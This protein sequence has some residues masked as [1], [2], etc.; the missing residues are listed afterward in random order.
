MLLWLDVVSIAQSIVYS[1]D[2]DAIIWKY[3]PLGFYNVQSLYAINNFR[4]VFSVYTPV[5]WK[6]N[7]PPRIH[8]FLWLMANNKIFTRDNCWAG[9][10]LHGVSKINI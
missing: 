5:V 4:G 1:A 9:L 3:H 6:L 7:I 2:K 10:P 8:V